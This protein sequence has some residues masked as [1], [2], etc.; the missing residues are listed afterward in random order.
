MADDAGRLSSGSKPPKLGRPK[1]ELALTTKAARASE[2]EV[3][4]SQ[5]PKIKLPP[6]EPDGPKTSGEE[7]RAEN[8]SD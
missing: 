5:V 1:A 7:E 2:D 3:P 6:V 4:S 8:I